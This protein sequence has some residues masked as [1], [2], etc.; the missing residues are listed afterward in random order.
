MSLTID[1]AIE[2]I[3]SRM[4]FGSRPGLIRVAALME[5]LDH[6][7]EKVP[8]IH[9]AG[10]NGKGST[11]TYVKYMLEELGLKVGTFTSPYIVRF[12]ERISINGEGIPDD[13]LIQYV[14]NYQKIIAEMDEIEEISGITEFEVLTGMAFD[15]FEQEQVDVAVVEVGLGGLLDSTNVC[16]PMLTGI[17]TIGLDHIEILGNTLEEIAA[18]KAGIIKEGI[19]VVTGNIGPSA[20]QVIQDK[21]ELEHAPI[22]RFNEDYEI[23]YH[24]PDGK[25][26]EV[27]DFL[28]ENGKIPK[29]QV[30]LIGEHQVENAGMAVEMF[31]QYCQLTGRVFQ[32]K[33]VINGLKQ[34]NWPGRME[35]VSDEPMIVLDGAHNTHAMKRLVKN[36][37]DEFGDYHINIL[38]SAITTKDVRGMLQMLKTIPNVK[39]Y[40]TTFEYPKA[41]HLEQ[42]A[43]MEDEKLSIVSLWQFGI[44][45]LLEHMGEGEMLL[46]TGSLYFISDVRKLLLNVSEEA[47]L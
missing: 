32:H 27:F 18:Q 21:A 47:K 1:E 15:Y 19:P 44:A 39:I 12:N 41:I 9:I 11:V 16:K 14:K 33:D 36:M 13:K 6:P 43:D 46:I 17:T 24:Q 22:Y 20:L 42:Y 45:E 29:L 37:K 30:R 2:W 10:T 5:R 34:A 31:Y 3:H 25:W 26:Q 35:L 4:P 28:N 40:L 8:T 23:T 7:E 38:F